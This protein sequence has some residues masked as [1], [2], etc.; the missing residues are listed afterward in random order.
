MFVCKERKKYYTV[1]KMLHI[2]LPAKV[3]EVKILIS[4]FNQVSNRNMIIHYIFTIIKYNLKL[5]L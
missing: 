5:A 2:T 1:T 4:N 3:N